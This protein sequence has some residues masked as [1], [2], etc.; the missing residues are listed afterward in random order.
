MRP[1]RVRVLAGLLAVVAVVSWSVL[2]VVDS[3][4]SAGLPAVPWSAPAVL[5]VV[6]VAVGL[7]VLAVRRRLAARPG[8]TPPDPLGMARTAVLGKAAAHG[9]AVLSGAYAGYAL[10]LVAD[11]GTSPLRRER[12]LAS[13]LAALASLA[14]SAAGVLLER[15]CRVRGDGPGEGGA[16]TDGAAA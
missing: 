7:T 15:A 1:T 10:L 12:L 5:A 13:A 16:G 3:R 8:T 9:G 4:G 6:A 14:L 2:S 11:A